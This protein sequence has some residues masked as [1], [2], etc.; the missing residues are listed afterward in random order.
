MNSG[1]NLRMTLF[2][3]RTAIQANKVIGP[4]QWGPL[5]FCYFHAID[6]DENQIKTNS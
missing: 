5:S 2:L 3:K 1:I 4:Q 6:F